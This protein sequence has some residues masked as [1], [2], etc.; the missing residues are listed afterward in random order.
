VEKQQE[1][2]LHQFVRQVT[3]AKDIG[4]VNILATL[5]MEQIIVTREEMKYLIHLITDVLSGKNK[6][7]KKL[8]ITQLH[9]QELSSLQELI[10][11]LQE[12]GN[13]LVT[14]TRQQ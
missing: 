12:Y 10:I 7:T 1:Q 11:H 9:L 5:Q 14:L 8:S 6:A 13:I 4:I 3:Q 2:L